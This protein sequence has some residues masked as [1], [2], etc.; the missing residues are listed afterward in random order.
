MGRSA[1]YT[2]LLS[3]DSL[4]DAGGGARKFAQNLAERC[5]GRLLL[6]ER[7]ERLA[8]AQKRLRR[9]GIALEFGGGVEKGFRRVAEALTLVEA[10]AEPERGIAG[11]PIIR[12]FA[13]EGAKAFLCEPVIPTQHVAIRQVEF[14][15]WSL[16]GRKRGD[17]CAGRI[18]ARGLWQAYGGIS[19]LT[20]LWWRAGGK[21][22]EGLRSAG[23]VGIERGIERIAASNGRSDGCWCGWCALWAQA[24]RRPWRTFGAVALLLHVMDLVLELLVAELKLLDDAGE[25]SNLGL[26]PLDPQQNVGPAGLRRALRGR[27][28]GAALAA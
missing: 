14:I 10:F 11:Q 16:R 25:L 19:H 3:L 18:A 7:S 24:A 4:F 6:A 13:Q 12:V 28:Y 17:G 23:R 21:R 2:L 5:A 15:L 22:T 26:Q 9:P 1:A 27:L 20:R 8:E